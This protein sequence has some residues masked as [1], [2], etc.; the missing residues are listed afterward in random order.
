MM[1]LASL[2]NTLKTLLFYYPS[3]ILQRQKTNFQGYKKSGGHAVRIYTLIWGS[4]F[5]P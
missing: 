5:N 4:E 3:Y 2:I 1:L